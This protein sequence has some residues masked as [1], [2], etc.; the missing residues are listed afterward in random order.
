MNLIA[1][2]EVKKEIWSKNMKFKNKF[3]FI[4]LII[5]LFGI[6]SVSASN[7]ND[8]CENEGLE[9]PAPDI[10]ID[11]DKYVNSDLKQDLKESTV[12][13]ESPEIN[14]D[15]EPIHVG[16]TA[17]IN[18]TVKNATGYVMVSVDNQSFNESL[19]NYQAKLSVSGLSWGSHN[20]AVFYSGD[21][22]YTPDFKLA[23]LYVE[24]M[25]TQITDI[26]IDEAFYSEDASI[27]VT[28]PSSVEGD[29]TIRFNDTMKTNITQRI[30]NGQA[31][32]TIPK[33]KAG[34]YKVN[35]VY[36][37]NSYY[38]VNDTEYRIF[39]VKKA[40]PNLSFVS[41]EGTIY[42]NATI[43][44]TI[45]E[46]IQGFV[47][48]TVGEVDYNNVVIEDGGAI[49]LT[50]NVLS[51]INPYH[52]TVRY[53]GNENFI[54]ST[55]ET[56]GTPKKITTYGI[57][58]V[59]G[60]I[61]VNDDEIVTVYVPDH[62]D[63]VVIWVNGNSYRNHSFTGNAAT[64][65]IKGLKEGIYTVTATVNDTEFDHKN[66]TSL[67]TVNK[68]YPSINITL[69]NQNMIYVGDTL[70]LIISVPADSTGNI[71]I[72]Y[73][74][75]EY[76]QKPVNGNATF[77][78][79]VLNY[80][81]NTLPVICYGDEKYELNVTNLYFT[82]FKTQP[83]LNVSAQNISINDSEEI[84]FTLPED[85][86]GNITVS[87]NKDTYTV[88]VSGG[89]GSLIIPKLHHG[90]YTVNATYNGDNKYSSC[91]NDTEMFR[92]IVNSGQMDIIDE[93]NNTL[94]IYLAENMQ[95]Y[96][97]VK[98]E[99]KTYNQPVFNGIAKV[100]LTDAPIGTHHAQITYLNDTTTEKLES[101][102]DVYVPKY[103]ISMGM[104]STVLKVG[105]VGYINITTPIN[106]TGNITIEIN[107]KSY[108]ATIKDGVA[109]FAVDNL[110]YGSKT[111]FV[112]YSGDGTYMETSTSKNLTVYKQDSYVLVSADNINVGEAAQINVIGPEDIS[113]VVMINVNG[114]SYTALL[115]DGS[116]IVEIPKLEN[117]TYNVIASYMENDKYLSNIN[118][119][120]FMVLKNNAPLT[121][122]FNESEIKVK[123]VA[124]INIIAPKDATGSIMIEI[125]GKTYSKSIENG[126]ARFEVSD[127][128]SGNKT[129]FVKYSGDA[130]YLQNS[131]SESLTVLKIQT[132]IVSSDV[133]SDYN[134]GS[135]LIA[136]L[137]DI[138][139]HAISGAEISVNLNG[140]KQLTTDNNGQ[141]KLSTDNLVPN[142][143]LATISF[144]E[145]SNYLSSAT[146]AKITINKATPKLIASKK[147]FKRSVKT[148]KYK[149]T[150]KTN[151]NKPLSS[152][153]V[154]I[155]IN[156]KTYTA[157]T[158]GKGVA[159]FKLTK[160]KKKGKYTGVVTFDGNQ[161]YNKVT[162][163][164]KITIK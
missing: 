95:G 116:G 99:D 135:Y 98:I 117:G 43:L 85:A 23:T 106:A 124:H 82:A 59:A 159:T 14:I 31:L 6:A 15:I 64:F 148:K 39:E 17:K 58:V 152:V 37:G 104:N 156:K 133:V 60:N 157:K 45:N 100:I 140:A 69:I 121:I 55:A 80:G 144:L 89:H 62:V 8:T 115:T 158:N 52:I 74:G 75:V 7:M 126:V 5:L 113:G 154:K 48:I 73:N 13:Q 76:S 141:I 38:D 130:A 120:N 29:I 162:S 137:K 155:K 123:H 33:F 147:T 118:N 3:V 119:T 110:N 136:T 128:T 86:T 161:C 81:S 153:S 41:F 142:S 46:E 109:R 65:N 68:V 150:L 20:V 63:D 163:N 127:L 112:K 51:E 146:T 78:I 97:I 35:V 84:I 160:L 47:N 122:I 12:N 131:T 9:M 67:F 32:F 49:M 138:E 21:Q 53:G 30:N 93:K 72:M 25:Q 10:S 90:N 26:S 92:V 129:L 16:E 24:R 111:M 143:Y 22:N 34:N 28:V 42:D 107:G 66:F 61:T 19:I 145:N 50:T 108:V 18:I 71:S 79:N 11:E 4:C 77:Y 149:V 83:F 132:V 70:K 94:S 151:Q 87:I 2:I 54:S 103:A 101:V 44:I 91:K 164:V 57:T 134:G 36:N 102:V 27:A 88:C 139:G 1:I 40:D 96:V 114:I 125:D 105:S 56:Y